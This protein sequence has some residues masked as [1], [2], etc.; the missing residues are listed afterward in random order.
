MMKCVVKIVNDFEPLTVF[1]KLFIFNVDIVLNI[2][3]ITYY[4][5]IQ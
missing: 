2:P 1:A 4:N 3:L 5:L